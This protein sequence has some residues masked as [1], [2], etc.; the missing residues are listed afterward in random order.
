MPRYRLETDEELAARGWQVGQ[1]INDVEVDERDHAREL[2]R[3]EVD[4]ERELRGV[5]VLTE[6]ESRR[7]AE[8]R[9]ERERRER[10]RVTESL[11]EQAE[12]AA[13]ERE[14]FRRRADELHRWLYQEE[15]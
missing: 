2:A 9:A 15:G 13:E 8:L 12:F 4:S 14:D 6:K 5:R 7:R 11:A 10:E 3:R 1:P